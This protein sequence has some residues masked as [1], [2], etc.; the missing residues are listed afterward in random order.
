[1]SVMTTSKRATHGHD[2]ESGQAMVGFAITVMAIMAMLAIVIDLG[3]V[4]VGQRRLDQNGADAAAFAV[5]KTLSTA[6]SPNSTVGLYFN[7][8]SEDLYAMVRKYAGL[9]ASDVIVR[10]YRRELA[11][12]SAREIQNALRP[13]GHP[14]GVVARSRH[15]DGRVLSRARP[16][17]LLV[18]FAARLVSDVPGTWPRISVDDRVRR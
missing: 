18:Q 7:V 16:E 1:M 4:V 8:P 10:P 12:I 2:G 5:G 3:L 17:E 6:V 13:L 11:A 14:R 9:S 15:R